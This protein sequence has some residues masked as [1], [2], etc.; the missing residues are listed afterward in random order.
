MRV[1]LTDCAEISARFSK[2]LTLKPI[3]FWPFVPFRAHA[4]ALNSFLR[5]YPGKDVEINALH[6]AACDYLGVERPVAAV[7]S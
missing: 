3:N 2:D 5:R 1:I 4:D 6:G 7:Q